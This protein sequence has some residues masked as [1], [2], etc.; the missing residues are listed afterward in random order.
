[1][2][3]SQANWSMNRLM[4]SITLLQ[5]AKQGQQVI[6]I[7]G[8]G[9]YCTFQR[10]EIYTTRYSYVAIASFSSTS[11][12]LGARTNGENRTDVQPEVLW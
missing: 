11:D 5:T 6:K 3:M 8:P 12:V 9:L 1:M 10:K 4:N 7:S 2:T